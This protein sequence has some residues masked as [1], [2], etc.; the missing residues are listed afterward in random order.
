MKSKEDDLFVDDIKSKMK[1]PGCFC[2]TANPSGKCCLS[3]VQAFI[4]ALKNL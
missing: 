2:E 4:K 3:D 1:S